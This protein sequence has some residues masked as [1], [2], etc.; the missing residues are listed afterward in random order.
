LFTFFCHQ[1]LANTSS[2]D[3]R[4]RSGRD[5]MEYDFSSG[6]AHVSQ[7]GEKLRMVTRVLRTEDFTEGIA[8][9]LEKGKAEHKGR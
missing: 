4:Q 7:A 8:A 5:F 9:H 1:F 3:C 6:T 2:V